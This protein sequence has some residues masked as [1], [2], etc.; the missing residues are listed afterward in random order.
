[1][2][3][4]EQI[5]KQAEAA[6]E[7]MRQ[8]A[9]QRNQDDE[10]E[11]TIPEVPDDTS[12]TADESTVPD[13]AVQQPRGE[14]TQG[15]NK[16]SEETFEQKYR[17]LQGMYNA[18]VPRLH[19]QNRELQHR[20]QQ[21]EQ[22]VSTLQSTPAAQTPDSQPAASKFVTDQDVTDYGDAIEVMRRAAREESAALY[23]RIAQLESM[24]TQVQSNVVPQVNAVAQ[25]QA[26][27]AEQLFWNGLNNAVPNWRDV[28]A[29]PDFQTWLLQVDPLTNIARQ[30]YLED[31]QRNLDVERVAAFFRVWLQNNSGQAVAQPSVPTTQSELEKQVAPGR[32]KN[33]GQPNTQQQARV[34]T[35]KDISKFYDDVRRGVYQGREKD[36]DR[37][38]RDIFLAQSEGRIQ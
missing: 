8:L 16:S 38:E 17:T 32:S 28:N 13:S 20:L 29:D 5:R 35:R 33:T 36:R 37:I 23:Q 18:E 10:S 14:Q 34:W 24:V 15:A 6:D 30:T 11:I 21:L 4:P 26:A 7:T 3:L 1:M 2:A 9:G 19:Q 12:N 22:L 25:R 31:A 27:T